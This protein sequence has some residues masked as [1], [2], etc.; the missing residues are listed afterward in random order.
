MQRYNPSV[1]E[2]K[3]QKIWEET[4]LYEV[5]EDASR[6]KT[7][8]TPMLPYPSG[9]GLHV[10][11]VRNYSIADVMAR[12]YRQRGFNVMSNIGWDSF[13]LPTENYA[14]KTGISPRETTKNNIKTFKKQLK[15][16][17]FSYDWSREIDTSDPN[18]YKWTQWIFLELF[19]HGLAYQAESW[20]WWCP[21]CKTV[22]ANEQVIN[23]CCWRHEDTPV[24]KKRLKQWFFKITDYAE[25]L[26]A[27]I[28]DLDWPD[29]IKTM[30]RNWIGKSQGAELIFK[31]K[32]GPGQIEVFT[33]RPDTV[34][35]ATFLVLSPEH[36][37]VTKLTTK[38]YEAKVES[39]VKQALIK[40]DIDR[41]DES[42]AKTGVFTGSFAVN[43]AT[44]A[45]VPIWVADYVLPGYGTG[46]IMAV[47]AHD[48]RDNDFAKAYDLPQRRVIDPDVIRT[49]VAH[50]TN[51]EAKN[52]IVAVVKNSEGE[53]L[54]INWGPRLGGRLFVGGTVEV[55]ED[56]A[57]AARREIREETG[58][59]QAKIK[60]VSDE[61]FHYRYFAHS[62][63]Q[64]VS[65]T[66]K[67]VYATVVGAAQD[68]PRLEADEKGKFKIEW[69]S[70][71]QAG[72]DIT[73]PLH[74]RAYEIYLAEKVYEGEG[75]L[76]NSGD[77]SGGD[78]STAREAIVEY[79]AGKQLASEQ[80]NFKIRD[81]LISRQRYW[82][83]PI[84]IIHC[85][86]CGP[87]AVPA[88]DLPVVLP[89]VKD[90][91]PTG[92]AESVLAAETDWVNT[93]CPDCGQTAAR[94][95]TDTM[96]GYAC[97]SWYMHRYC[98]PH[99]TKQAWDP[100]KLNYWFD[101]D[102][103]FGGDHAVSHLLYF[104]FWHKFFA[105]IGLSNSREPIKRLV[106]NGYVKAEDGRKM[107]KSLNNVI[108][109]LQVVDSGYG[110]DALRM[111][112]LFMGPYDQDVNWNSQGVP[113]TF[114]FLQRVWTLVEDFLAAEEQPDLD[115]Q[116]EIEARLN[117]ALHRTVKRV[118]DDLNRLS[119][120]TAIAALMEFVNIANKLAPE[121]PFGAAADVWRQAL[122]DLIALMA[123]FAPYAAE[124][125]WRVL[126]H[127]ESVHIDSW[128]EFN[129]QLLAEEL[130]T[131]VVQ[132][133]GKVRANLL[134]AP[135]T[136]EAEVVETAL[137]EDN[138][139]KYLS[140]RQPTRTISVADRLVNFV[141]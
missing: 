92:R 14:I 104:R 7:Y 5:K 60:G 122:N 70:P 83:A 77:F 29:S 110:A 8:A 105:D 69:V 37:M 72:R 78:S 61:T 13:G 56:P 133:N 2:P 3:W 16:M 103:Y 35:G 24:I 27:S 47:P 49:D 68:K 31:L 120:N 71:E 25:E 40:T 137:K 141:I 84:P 76:V 58:Y 32:D 11:H 79:L 15:R 46:A 97:S 33:T 101:V 117:T 20:Q 30:Q 98:D 81:W 26:L 53:V 57:D 109:P 129:A 135:G 138:V 41:M 64:A 44:N 48:Q 10:G 131:I 125:L 111:F 127:D 87:V 4:N 89:E 43:P 121:L 17:G 12:F 1:I 132:I 116:A 9:A 50:Q 128:P 124:E 21:K 115:N 112:V 55:D 59:G 90:F 42:R 134:V 94:R 106:F 23:G 22:L 39:Y 19:K 119:F 102:F 28:E 82:G 66:T 54:T 123:P 6:P 34:F 99:N 52:K 113:G 88:K 139:A 126:E 118:T 36:S 95:E 136:P 86:K 45:A 62:K 100:A 108:D 140:G 65:A 80:V 51:F 75:R 74:R 96:D 107:S 38:A 63:S 114:R 67:F 91:A 73:D 85:P 93:D 18:Y 130:I